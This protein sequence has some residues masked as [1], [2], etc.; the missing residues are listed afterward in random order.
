MAREAIAHKVQGRGTGHIDAHGPAIVRATP[1]REVRF[2]GKSPS[3]FRYTNT[4][5]GYGWYRGGESTLAVPEFLWDLMHENGSK[6]HNSY[7]LDFPTEEAAYAA[8]S[9]AAILFAN[10]TDLARARGRQADG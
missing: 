1:V 8:L 9:A 4:H 2:V 3:A 10:R 5:D 7:W 6:A